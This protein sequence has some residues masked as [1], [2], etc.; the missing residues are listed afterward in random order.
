MREA[1]FNLFKAVWARI[2]YGYGTENVQQRIDRRLA[3]AIKAFNPRVPRK[4]QAKV[5][6]D[7]NTAGLRHPAHSRNLE[8]FRE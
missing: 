7:N 5:I 2:A 6:S 3:P 8:L 1:V 4:E